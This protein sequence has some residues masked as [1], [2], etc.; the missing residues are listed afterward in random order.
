[1]LKLI[2]KSI[3]SY[4]DCQNCL[5]PAKILI[6]LE[7]CLQVVM[8]NLG[9]DDDPYLIFESLNFK[10]E[11]LTQGDLVRNYL[12]MRFRHSISDGGEQKRVYSK[13]WIPLENMLQSNLPEFLRHY[14]MKE[15]DDIK[16]GGIYAAI[17]KK[18]KDLNSTEAVEA[19][20][21]SM[22]RF[23]EFYSKFLLPVQEDKVQIRN[24]L[25]NIK[26]LKVTTSYPLL[27]R[28]FDALQSEHLS[29]VDLEKCL[30]LIESFVVRR[31]VCG[32]PTNPLNKLFIQ[33]SKNFPD[34]DHVQWLHR[35]LSASGGTSRFPKDTEFAT[36]FL[37]Q[38]QYG[39]GSTRFILCRLE[40]SFQHK[41][42]VDL[43]TATIEHILPQTLTQEWKE[44]LG[45]EPEKVH[46]DL[47]NVFGNLTLTSYNSEL[48]NLPFLEKKS[49]LE[50]TH[51]ELNR[52][53]LQQTSWG[54]PEIE[55]RAKILLDI[56][57]KIWLAP[58]EI[59]T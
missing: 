10:G 37:T 18:L 54:M 44:A 5:S 12:L 31:A 7:Q 4:F 36:A 57:N 1:M 16:K 41:E 11:P 2:N 47:V 30:S 52:W 48:S 20:A 55:K 27:L 35:S 8:I 34:T 45:A 6:T 39:R 59:V 21:E 56:A 3:L 25:E 19:E 26:E 9:D 23:G 28:L 50:N 53:V 40:K 24:C 38:P 29:D 17:K 32:V 51:I 42:T 15:G 33:W 46:T 22:R 58:L 49:K 43:S 13:Y 14:M